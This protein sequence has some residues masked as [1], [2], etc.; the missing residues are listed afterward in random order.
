MSNK[1]LNQTKSKQTASCLNDVLDQEAKTPMSRTVLATKNGQT[2]NLLVTFA[3]RTVFI[4]LL[5]EYY[6]GVN[7]LFVDILNVLSFAEL[8][9]GSAMTFALYSPVAKGQNEKVRQLIYF[10][11]NAYRVIA[12]VVLLFGLA[13]LPFL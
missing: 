3:S 12:F 13:L 1:N 7:Y 11:R 9:F 2:I 8:G 4:Y 6:L 5:G 10:Y